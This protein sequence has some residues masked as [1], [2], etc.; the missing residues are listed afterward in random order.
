MQK[1]LKKE[2]PGVPL[3]FSVQNVKDAKLLCF[4][5][6][7]DP[8]TQQPRLMLRPMT[9]ALIYYMAQCGIS[10][11]TE[12]SLPELWRRL[13]LM[14]LFGILYGFSVVGDK[15]RPC[16][17]D[18]PTLV[19][20]L[21]LVVELSGKPKMWGEFRAQLI[22]LLMQR[23]DQY[24]KNPPPVQSVPRPAGKAP[25]H[26]AG[27]GQTDKPEAVLRGDQQQPAPGGEPG[28]PVVEPEKSVPDA[29]GDAGRTDGVAGGKRPADSPTGNPAVQKTEGEVS[30][31]QEDGR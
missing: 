8:D 7:M 30:G 15:V 21:G 31:P 22:N 25:P 29:S 27:Q 24:E 19:S 17:I 9:Q 16:P 23:I 5:P 11:V 1:K 20:H 18:Y 13:N 10:E 2:K 12:K 26:P 4:T 14:Q 3:K 28:R 6:V